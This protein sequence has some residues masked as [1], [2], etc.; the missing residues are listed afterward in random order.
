MRNQ[1][2]KNWLPLIS[3][4]HIAKLTI[5][6]DKTP[7]AFTRNARSTSTLAAVRPHGRSSGRPLPT[8]TAGFF[9]WHPLPP[10][11]YA[12]ARATIPRSH[13][14]GCGL[15][16]PTQ[17]GPAPIRIVQ[18]P[19][20]PGWPSRSAESGAPKLAFDPTSVTARVEISAD[21]SA[22]DRN[23]RQRGTR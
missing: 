8:A 4:S 13:R 2:D 15:R 14:R 3:C 5:L 9:R 23:S 12:D 21:G 18:F 20:A 7:G 22:N 10:W 17:F 11:S 1:L 16:I 19:L 6:G